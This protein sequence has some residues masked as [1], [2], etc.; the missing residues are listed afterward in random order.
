MFEVSKDNNPTGATIDPVIEAGDTLPTDVAVE[1]ALQDAGVIG[2]DEDI[3]VEWDDDSFATIYPLWDA[4]LPA[5]CTI[6]K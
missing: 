1:K 4:K 5:I 3:F 2:L 6:S